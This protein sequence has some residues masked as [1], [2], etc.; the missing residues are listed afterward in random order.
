MTLTRSLFLT[1]SNNRTTTDTT[2]R[3]AV[4][5]GKG[6]PFK[7]PTVG[8]PPQ[9]FGT[10]GG[11][12]NFL[13][14]MENWGGTLYYEGSIV[15]M[16]YNH[17]A[18]GT[19]KCCT[20]VYSPPTRAYQVRHELPDAELVAAAH[21]HAAGDQHADVHAGYAADA[22]GR[23]SPSSTT[24]AAPVPPGAAFILQT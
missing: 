4:V 10:D 1:T 8:G 16:Y 20:T 24:Q 19:F 17:Q 18:V 14:Y 2:Y 22:V 9:D 7:Q 6:I 21:A 12:H 23:F 3:V 11:A 5:G 13:R 15:S